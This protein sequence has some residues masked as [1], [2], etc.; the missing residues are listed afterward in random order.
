MHDNVMH[1]RVDVITA[2]IVY[3]LCVARLKQESAS[4]LKLLTQTLCR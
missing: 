3:R 4:C 2:R 1:I